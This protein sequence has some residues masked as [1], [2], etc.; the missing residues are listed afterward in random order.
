MSIQKRG[1]QYPLNRFSAQSAP[2]LDEARTEKDQ[3]VVVDDGRAIGESV[4]AGQRGRSDGRPL[5]SEEII[6]IWKDGAPR[7][8]VVTVRMRPPF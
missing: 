3:D 1:H 5:S 8:Q 6:Q 2:D 7:H 4:L